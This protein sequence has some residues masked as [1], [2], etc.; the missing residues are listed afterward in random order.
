[1]ES[2]AEGSPVATVLTASVCRDINHLRRGSI[3]IRASGGTTSAH[4]DPVEM[5]PPATRHRHVQ[6]TVGTETSPRRPL[7]A[8][9][10]GG[11]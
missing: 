7:T 5:V 9:V 2:A 8:G 3:G 10:N 11:S 1:M 6:Q 4:R